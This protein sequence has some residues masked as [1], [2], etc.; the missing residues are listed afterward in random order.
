MTSDGYST[1]LLPKI[2]LTSNTVFIIT[3]HYIFV[4]VSLSFALED[5]CNY[6]LF[7]M[8]EGIEKIL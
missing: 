7:L 3:V 2:A 4:F 1:I 6:R 5:L 8:T